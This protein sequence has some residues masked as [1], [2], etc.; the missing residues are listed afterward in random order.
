MEM[1]KPDIM[2]LPLNLLQLKY[3]QNTHR[4]CQ[5]QIHQKNNLPQISKDKWAET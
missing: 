1:F 2:P 3:N 5:C 4:L